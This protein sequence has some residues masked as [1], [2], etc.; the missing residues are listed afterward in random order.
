MSNWFRAYGF[1]EILPE[2]LIG[3]YPTD[4]SDIEMLRWIGVQRILNLCE[5]EEYPPG[6]REVIDEDLAELGIE[7]H[8]IGLTDFGRVPVDRIDEAVAL[9]NQWLDEG[10][11]V[12]LH[13]RA[14]QQRSATLAAAVVTIRQQLPPDEAIAFVQRMKPSADP[15]PHQ[16]EDLLEWAL[17]RA[18]PPPADGEP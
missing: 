5:D 17:L 9:L 16:R 18:T 13:C 15:L 14:G 3:A 11:R 6:A 4:H 1:S 10:Q 2:F 12:Y 8:R 7:E